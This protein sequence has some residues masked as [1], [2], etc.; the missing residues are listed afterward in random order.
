LQCVLSFDA[1]ERM[2]ADDT[3]ATAQR[4]EIGLAQKY[5]YPKRRN[6]GAGEPA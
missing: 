2:P 3:S 5:L 4:F 6:D 1:G